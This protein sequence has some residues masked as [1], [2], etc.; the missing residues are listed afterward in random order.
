VFVENTGELLDGS[1]TRR[2]ICFSHN[3]SAAKTVSG[4][5]FSFIVSLHSILEKIWRE[6]AIFG[7]PSWHEFIKNQAR[8]HGVRQKGY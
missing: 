1:L 7:F 3:P 8:S 6:R 4:M 5:V 2:S